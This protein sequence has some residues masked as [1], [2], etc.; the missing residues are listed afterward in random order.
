MSP[1]L[2]FLSSSC[3]GH[4]S[5]LP[6]E[7]VPHLTIF[8][9][10][11]CFQTGLQLLSCSLPA[12][13]QPCEV[14]GHCLLLSPPFETALGPKL[15]FWRLVGLLIVST[16]SLAIPR[17]V[18]ILHWALGAFLLWNVQ[19]LRGGGQVGNDLE[20]FHGC[21]PPFHSSY[22][23]LELLEY[24]TSQMLPLLSVSSRFSL[25][26]GKFLSCICASFCRAFLFC[27]HVS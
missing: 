4:L 11:C 23:F 25:F 22:L 17:S 16:T 8:T 24:W 15:E 12:C 18:Y 19:L 2:G 14:L 26:V 10:G 1:I 27:S 20:L 6:P 9:V 7:S 5:A 13:T 3:A 21:L